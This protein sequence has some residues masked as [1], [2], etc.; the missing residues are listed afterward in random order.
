[1]KRHVLVAQWSICAAR[2]YYELDGQDVLACFRK[3]SSL[4][5]C[6]DARLLCSG[7]WVR[8]DPRLEA[9]PHVIRRVADYL[10]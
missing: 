7:V 9:E 10:R 8:S 3:T 6:Q 1:M 4:S 5:T 2:L